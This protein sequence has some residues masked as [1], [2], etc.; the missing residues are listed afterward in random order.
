MSKVDMN[1]WSEQEVNEMIQS[2][3]PFCLYLYTP[4]CGTC[5]VASRMLTVVKELI[6]NETI[7]KCD[8]NYMPAK[9][10]EWL[11]ESVP[12]LLIFRNGEIEKRIYAFRSVDYLYTIIKETLYKE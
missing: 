10:R 9:A 5:Q 1:D 7:G 3:A 6:P 4:M 2:N 11:I 8:L 12:C